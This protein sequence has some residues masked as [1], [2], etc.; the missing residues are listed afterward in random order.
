MDQGGVWYHIAITSDGHVIRTFVNGCEA[1]RDYTSD[2]MTGLYA[3]PADGRF[4]IG[5]SWYAERKN[6]V[7]KV[8]D[9]FLNGNLEEVRISNGVLGRNDW[10]VPKPE[11]YISNYGSNAAQALRN[12]GD[13]NFV[14]LPDTQNTV[15][16]KSDVMDAAVRGIISSADKMNIRG[17]V[18]L[19]DVVEDS[20][21][22]EQYKTARDVFY[23]LPDA[24]VPLLMQPGNH[25]GD[26]YST[27]F[28]EA[29]PAWVSKTSSYLS[30]HGD[31]SYMLIDAGSYTY[32][33]ISLAMYWDQDSEDW[34]KSV[35]AQYPN[36]PTI[37]TSHDIFDCS[38]TQPSSIALDISGTD[39][40]NI[41]KNYNQVFMMVAGHN[42]GAGTATF[43]NSSGNPVYG[44]LTDYQFAYNGGNGY[45]RYLEFDENNNKIYYSAYSPYEG[46]LSPSQKS[47]FDINFLSGAGN[48]GALDLNFASR[49]PGMAR[50][51]AA[52]VPGYMSGEYHTHTTQSNDAP[53]ETTLAS[54]LG[55]AFHN[56]AKADVPA[57]VTFRSSDL[58]YLMLSDHLRY[59]DSNPDGV[60]GTTARYIG[61]A[62][63]LREIK[64]LKA[65]GKYAG[66]II[67]S[68]FEWDM[69]GL[70]HASACVLNK[71]GEVDINGTHGFE[72]LF[73]DQKND[74]DSLF[75]DSGIDEASVYGAR[76][77]TT[78]GNGRS[79]VQVA[80]NAV[81]WLK[82]NY[83]D[84]FVLP[85]H[86]SRHNGGSG[87]V[88]IEN[89][90]RLNDT[91]PNIVFGFEGMP[92]N[93]MS[94]DGTRCEMND[95][96]GGADVMLSRVG[97]VWDSMLCEG[98]RF[99]VFANSDFHFKIS[100]NG[101]Y[102]SGYWPGEYS[103]N[104]TFIK[105]NNFSDVV[106]GLRSGNSFSVYGDLIDSLG[107]TAAQNGSSA[108]MGENL[109]AAKGGTVTLTIRF[110]SPAKN[111]YAPISGSA[112]VSSA[113]SVD[114]IDLISGEVTGKL[115]A[116]DYGKDSNSTVKVVKT[117]TASD[118]GKPDKDG[119]CTVTFTV[120]ADKDRYYRLRGTNLSAAAGGAY[121][122]ADGNPLRDVAFTSSAVPDDAARF[123]DINNRNYSGL[124]F[125]SNPIF[126]SA[127]D[128]PVGPDDTPAPA[129][130]PVV[131]SSPANGSLSLSSASAAAG[132]TVTVTP[133]P[134]T[135]Y[136][137]AS[138]TV[139]DSNGS[140]V[141]AIKNSDGTYSF[142]MPAGGVSVGA[143]FKKSGEWTNPY[144]DV[145]DTAW[146]Y[147]SVKY[148]SEKALFGGVSGTAFGPDVIMTR[149]MLWTVLGRLDGSDISGSGVYEKAR[150][151]AMARGIS[152]GSAPTANITREQLAAMLW[153]YAGSPAES[154]DLS[155]FPDSG[156][157][158]AYAKP[159]V[160][161]AVHNGIISG[162]SGKL[163]PRDNAARAQV[164]A[165]LERFCEVYGK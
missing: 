153:R 36:C 148:V 122:G 17:V 165:M 150:A 83:P 124:W 39:L 73:A 16:F 80:Y 56:D 92:G 131:K 139:K 59:S 90:R 99:W 85:N 15:K 66:K 91:A 37:V 27:S 57:G 24:G 1:F 106:N 79:N 55:A 136:E 67:G 144:G 7:D 62:Q 109:S 110:R 8:L 104:Y 43:T 50:N 152:N 154:A 116:A 49:F 51:S 68:G 114:H 108:T 147:A 125:Y 23:Q 33:V 161:W 20:D 82:N 128:I 96:Y 162:M 158:S 84:S 14:L 89:L 61:I 135:G 117:F 58:D 127:A 13:Y 30:T 32:L 86:P 145:S 142:K 41:V 28:S 146:Y 112:A 53:A 3:D 130:Y 77:A 21:S 159:A 38:D 34:F 155:A 74:A 137:T 132:T 12:A 81:D 140:P 119:F 64:S 111:N 120:P 69:P 31:N 107:F 103:K 18:H 5:A 72:W 22:S 157:V 160:E 88:T 93:Q 151:W 105:G 113:P 164:A 40:W 78:A 134:D 121:I 129:F 143:A 19:G 42:H 138:V 25:D 2:Q 98:R 141:A 46:T 35:L 75:A 149:Q 115:A 95:I 63:Q 6:G 123:N 163:A 76:Q 87:A 100:S 94:P 10:L 118:W 70:D 60:S 48:E 156:N 133:R 47:F 54:S 126:V 29:S 45:F 11:S 71:K 4:R 101:S 97:G 9:K 44:V 52:F 102:S 65:Q 26:E